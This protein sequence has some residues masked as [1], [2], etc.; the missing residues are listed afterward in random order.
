MRVREWLRDAVLVAAAAAVGWWAHGA[1]APVHAAGGDG[2]LAFQFMPGGDQSSLSIYNPS[3]RTLYVYPR[4]G[5]GNSHLNCQY[6][7]HLRSPGGSID[8]ENCR[9]GEALP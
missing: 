1:G 6:M 3:D 7:F 2:G 5:V 9:P 8:R 4:V